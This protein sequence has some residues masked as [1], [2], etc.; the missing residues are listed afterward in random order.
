VR[1]LLYA[2]IGGAVVYFLMSRKEKP[3]PPPQKPTAKAKKPSGEKP[4]TPEELKRLLKD[5]RRKTIPI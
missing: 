2:A 1:E 3:K 4:L 5:R